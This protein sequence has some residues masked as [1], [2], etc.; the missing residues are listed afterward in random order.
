MP[1]PAF[2]HARRALRRT[3]P[4]TLLCAALLAVPAVAQPSVTAEIR[5]YTL[6]AGALSQ[7]LSEFA[8][9]AGVVLSFDAAVLRGRQ[10]P[11][12]QGRY[13]VDVGFAALL[14][15][16]GYQA[17][18]TA[19]GNYVLRA[20]PAG[21]LLLGPLRVQGAAVDST[22][23]GTG[24]YAAQ[25]AAVAS[26]L[27]LSLRHTPQSVSVITRQRLD[28]QNLNSVYEAMKFTTGMTV[29]PYGSEI[30]N[31]SARGYDLDSIR[32]DGVAI[33][34]GFG[35]W[36]TGLFD[37]A[38][39]DRIEVLRGPS[40]LLQGS[41]EPGGAV[42]LSRKRAPHE[43]AV[44][45]SFSAG[46]W[47]RYRAEADVGGPLSAGGGVRGRLVYV[48][49]DKQSF[50]DYVESEKS[51]VYGTLEF[52]LGERSTL[53]LGGTYQ[54][55]QSLPYL[56]VAYYPDFTLPDISRS[57]FLG[58]DWQY[59]D[60]IAASYFAEF[61]HRLA[62]GG[63]AKLTARYTKRE[64]DQ[65]NM[66]WTIGDV[67]PAT[68]LV[69]LQGVASGATQRDLNVDA[70]VSTPITAFGRSHDL[71][72]GAD[73]R[74]GQH[75][76]EYGRNNPFTFV[77]VF[78]PDPH[79]PV[80]DFYAS[81]TGGANSITSQYG[82]YSQARLQ[83]TDPFSAIV[84]ARVSWWEIDNRLNPASSYSVHGEFTPY[85]GVVY[86]LDANWSVYASYSSIFQPQTAVDRSGDALEPRDGNQLELG[87]KGEF[88]DGRLNAYAAVYRIEDENRAMTDPSDQ[89]FSIAAGKVR[90][91][92]FETEINGELL[93]GWEL[94]AGYAYTETEF[95]D[96][97]QGARD[98]R[99]KTFNA[100]TPRNSFNLWSKYTIQE[101]ALS[102]FSIAAGLKTISS[103]YN[104]NYV[105]GWH[106]LKAEQGGYTLL[107]AQLGYRFNEHY[108]VTLSG[109]NLTDKRYLERSTPGWGSI[110]GEPRNYTLTLRGSF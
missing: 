68:G 70:F 66:A 105:L 61:D 20:V 13:A 42:N 101:G 33:R 53:S 81:G 69:R 50:V 49:E 10:S 15:G 46:S 27:P 40:G 59:K 29:T 21:A 74:R 80:P 1:Q 55:S 34:S 67:D 11:G 103:F 79:M 108:T 62:N 56:T 17:V 28:D 39:F 100:A 110:F 5:A 97:Q 94:T 60:D 107:S 63:Q 93:P 109:N 54:D 43:F 75:A 65:Q 26:K 30:G 6:P 24:S 25:S 102:D 71:V 89:L 86:D 57:T 95:L 90:A 104:Q 91:E 76:L 12:L 98:L 92:G 14:A 32:I 16:S 8:A 35:A 58:A 99:G 51:A 7:V 44:S 73:Y 18:R 2:P 3:L 96:G 31:I 19:E 48:Q 37:L 36:S 106:R 23:E 38:F 22:T 87:L 52:D 82:V 72:F 77:D 4:A 88:Y 9:R 41:G 83:L 78:D 84:G 45:G 47:D 85:L 64:M